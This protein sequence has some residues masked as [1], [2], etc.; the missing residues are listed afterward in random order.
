MGERISNG[1]M[2]NLV[3]GSR[4]GQVVVRS[5]DVFSTG[6]LPKAGVRTAVEAE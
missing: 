5:S 1:W 6:S 3:G 4:K 2:A